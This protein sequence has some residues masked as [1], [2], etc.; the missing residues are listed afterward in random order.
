MNFI[1]GGLNSAEEKISEFSLVEHD[2][3]NMQ[4]VQNSRHMASRFLMNT[5]FVTF[6]HFTA[7]TTQTLPT[8]P[9]F[10]HH[11]PHLPNSILH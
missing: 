5:N 10:T 6:E 11:P 7:K 3:V 1:S 8:P 4:A 2:D 9:Y